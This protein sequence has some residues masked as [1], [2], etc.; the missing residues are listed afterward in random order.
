MQETTAAVTATGGSF[1]W[2]MTR[3]LCTSV[4]LLSVLG[5]VWTAWQQSIGLTAVTVTAVDPDAE[6][7][8]PGLPMLKQTHTLPD[9]Q[10]TINLSNGAKI[11]AGAK[12]DASAVN[13][14]TWTLSEPVATAQ[15]ASVTLSEQD[16]LISDKLAEVQ[17]G[18]GVAD[19]DLYHFQFS[20]QR[21]FAV[22]IQS[23]FRTTLG[24][25]VC[26]AFF[27]AVFL[28]LFLNFAV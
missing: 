27:C 21:S 26:A 12:L 16:T 19:T 1:L 6:P 24:L 3:T 28:I 20:T 2:R 25:A 15:I 10:L 17:L 13:G 7:R 9:Y 23:F 18:D 4:I 5:T 11:D 22:G 8:D 14:I